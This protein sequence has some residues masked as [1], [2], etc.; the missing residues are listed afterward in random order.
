MLSLPDRPV[1]VPMLLSFFLFSFFS[2]V[3]DVLAIAMIPSLSIFPISLMK[4]Y[5]PL[6]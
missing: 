3:M 6:P 2:G 1:S 5:W 4:G